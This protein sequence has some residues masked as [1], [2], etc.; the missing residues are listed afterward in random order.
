MKAIFEKLEKS[1][2]K[3]LVSLSKDEFDKYHDQALKSVQEVVVVDGFRKGN[4]PENMII[5]KYGE[6]IVLEE[7]AH[8][9]ISKTFYETVINE[10]KDKKE[11][12]KIIPIS[13]PKIS[14]TKIG[15]DSDFEY[16]ALFPIL[17]EVK[18]GDYKKFAKEE[19]LKTEESFL[20]ELKKINTN[21]KAS[22][23]FDIQDQEIADVMENLRK[24]RNVGAHV[25]DDGVVH[26]HS[27][28]EENLDIENKL[29]ESTLPELN[30][31]FAQSFG[32]SFKTLQDLK[33]KIKE[34]LT[35]EK[36]AKIIDKERNNILEMRRKLRQDIEKSKQEIFEKFN[37]VKTGKVKIIK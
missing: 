20:E 35:L 29:E 5:E 21:A 9:A 34:N 24:A 19:K 33:D 4:A 37:K 22:E 7:M 3:V 27:H 8:I 18:I 25:H 16:S 28:S 30:D 10:N 11:E 36:K 14:I 31:E 23:I 32:D 15:K 12:D 1:E 6:M 26:E 13:E 17:P 2:A